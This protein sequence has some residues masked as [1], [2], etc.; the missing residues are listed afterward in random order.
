MGFPRHCNGA[1]YRVDLAK[2]RV[3]LRHGAVKRESSTFP[4]AT[5]ALPS[6]LKSPSAGDVPNPVGALT[7]RK[8]PSNQQDALS[9][10][11]VGRDEVQRVTTVQVDIT[12]LE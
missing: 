12:N 4:S 6:L 3:D 7:G 11:E 5:S 10:V 8:I 1:N 9:V 2:P